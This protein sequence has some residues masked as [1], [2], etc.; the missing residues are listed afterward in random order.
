MASPLRLAKNSLHSLI[1]CCAHSA[2][3]PLG[4]Y[5]RMHA[6]RAFLGA[7]LKSI[8]S[9]SLGSQQ[10][11]STPLSIA[12]LTLRS[13][14]SARVRLWTCNKLA[15]LPYRELRSLCARS[16]RLLSQNACCQGPSGCTL[17]LSVSPFRLATN[18]LHSLI[19]SCAHSALVPLGKSIAR[20]ARD[21]SGGREKILSSF[22]DGEALAHYVQHRHGGRS[23]RV[24][25]S[26]PVWSSRP[27]QQQQKHPSEQHG[28]ARENLGIADGS[29]FAI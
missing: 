23:L 26:E 24:V 9:R 3:V 13:F 14:H 18:S 15:P 1:D 8:W 2:L 20:K 19:A 17:E 7:A 4:C 10:T 21:R 12:A 22:T 27:L 11:R 16:T 6:V 25:F 5:R 29:C 28:C